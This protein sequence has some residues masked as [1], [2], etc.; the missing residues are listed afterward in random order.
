MRWT[1][2]L[3]CAVAAALS[4]AGSASAEV[5]VR[6]GGR[7]LTVSGEPLL[8][9]H[10]IE[11]GRSVEATADG[12]LVISLKLRRHS[13]SRH[14][15]SARAVLELDGGEMDRFVLEAQP[16]GRY[17]A[18]F[19]FTPGP[20][21]T[22]QI[23][24]GLG[25]HSIAVRA[26]EGAVV[27][28]F[29]EGQEE[30]EAAPLVAQAPAAAVSP[31]PAPTQSP[32]RASPASGDEDDE[33]VPAKIAEAEPTEIAPEPA[34]VE[35]PG[36]TTESERP[37][38][39]LL[40]LRAGSATQ[41]QVGSTGFGGGADARYYVAHRFSLGVGAD[42]YDVAFGGKVSGTLA[43][44]VAPLS[45]GVSVVAVPVL[46]EGA[47][48]QPLGSALTLTLGL[49][50]GAAYEQ[51]NRSLTA[52]TSALTAPGSESAAP[53]GEILADLSMHAPGGRVG[54]EL[55]LSSTL[56]QDVDGVARGAVVGAFL[57]E[58]GYQFLL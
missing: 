33:A 20:E 38:H 29:S 48:D 18:G 16:A 57:A 13:R 32:P 37:P 9:Y 36:T 45:L 56:P 35:R 31:A 43:E 4:A 3:R 25:H 7:V 51:F 53:V 27:V 54:I 55:R 6:G 12:P 5:R 46:L 49:G 2:F 24:L 39:V 58:V 1:L 30:L 42:A 28:A 21:K 52:G 11:A 10:L 8:V 22:R 41:T 34:E 23:K 15:A 47:Y 44:G 26:L 50:A 17:L 19:G 14:G 40:E